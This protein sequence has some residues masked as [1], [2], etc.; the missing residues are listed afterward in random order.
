MSDCRG[1]RERSRERDADSGY[2]TY[3][4]MVGIGLTRALG[5]DDA[6]RV[7]SLTAVVTLNKS[8][9]SDPSGATPASLM[10]ESTTGCAA[11]RPLLLLTT[12]LIWRFGLP[13]H[14][15]AA[16]LGLLLVLMFGSYSFADLVDGA[17]VPTLMIDL[18]VTAGGA[19]TL[20]GAVAYV[21]GRRR[22]SRDQRSR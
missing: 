2:C 1:C 7:A 14:V 18:A 15:W 16:V 4:T 20:Y 22:A 10:M 21:I 12:F 11:F 17:E 9:L 6:T 8:D 5:P 19:L 13:A 3:L